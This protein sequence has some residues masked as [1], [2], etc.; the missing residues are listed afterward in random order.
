MTALASNLSVG[1]KICKFGSY[2]GENRFSTYL[3][4]IL[5]YSILAFAKAILWHKLKGTAY[6]TLQTIDIKIKKR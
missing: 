3:I 2:K 1:R 6:V 5:I 4:F